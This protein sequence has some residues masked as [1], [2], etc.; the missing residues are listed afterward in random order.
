MSH[1]RF[2]LGAREQRIDSRTLQL[3]EYL[4][5]G[6]L[7]P[8]PSSI[9]WSHP[10]PNW[11]MMLNDKEGDCTI[12]GAMHLDQLWTANT[13]KMIVCPDADIEKAYESIGGYDPNHPDTTDNGCVMLD[14]LNHWRKVGIGGRKIAGYTRVIPTH[15][16]MV[17]QTIN[18]FGGIYLGV[19]LPLSA[20]EQSIWSVLPTGPTGSGFPNSWGGHCVPVVAYDPT[21]LICVTWG[22]LLK[23]TW[24]FF[25]T[26]VSEAYAV[27]SN[28]WLKGGKNSPSGLAYSELMTDLRLVTA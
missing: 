14:V 13:G 2:K 5:I 25:R 27:L 22:A 3:A 24:S 18:L 21:Y 4:N 28:D 17:K 10:V 11:P 19:K 9:D 6:R 15:Q 23:M 12:A 26:Y 8:A 16:E 1:A 7:R 20:Q